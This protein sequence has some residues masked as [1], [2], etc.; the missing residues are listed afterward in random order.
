VLE[1]YRVTNGK[2]FRL[3]DHDPDDTG[4][5]LIARENSQALLASGI[6]RLSEL[7]E[8]LYPHSTWALLCVFQAMDAAG[9]DGTIKHV[10]SGINPQG[11]QV[12]AFKPPSPE[13]LGHDFLWRVSRALPARGHIGIFNRS[14]Y[15]EVLV[16]RVHPEFLGRQGLPTKLNGKR[17][18]DRRLQDIANWESY[19]ARQGTV[20]LKF[21]LNI[22]IEE[23]KRR[24]FERLDNPN[25]NWKF[26]PA[27]ISERQYWDHYMAAYEAAIR[28]TATPQAPWYVVP[29]DQKWFARVVVVAAMIEALEHL[30]LK[31]PAAPPEIYARLAEMRQTLSEE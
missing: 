19:V 8:L 31:P 13:E 27:D 12:T 4:G 26:S 10:M 6:A 23:Q 11:V 7:Q 3:K 18:W 5:K 15:E 30:R 16:V 9:K 2:N 24:F 28:A 29:A 21:F 25:K 14:H 20:I 17:I 1:R 22:S